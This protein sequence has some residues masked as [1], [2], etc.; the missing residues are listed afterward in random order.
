MLQ[1]VVNWVQQ[2]Q[3]LDYGP[4]VAYMA[5]SNTNKCPACV[6]LIVAAHNSLSND[7]VAGLN[8]TVGNAVN[9]YNY[10][11]ALTNHLNTCPNCKNHPLLKK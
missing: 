10:F 9:G 8:L 3:A 5:G 11:S 7:E 4:Y 2:L 1:K 6:Q